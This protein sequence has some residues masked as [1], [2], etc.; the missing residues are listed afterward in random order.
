MHKAGGWTQ[1]NHPTTCPPTLPLCLIICRGC[2][3]DYTTKETKPA[4]V[5]ALEVHNGPAGG[6]FTSTAIDFWDSLLASGERVTAVA[7]S[8]SHR[9][10]GG[11]A[12]IGIGTT[13]VYAEEL[14]EAGIRDAVLAGHAYL[15]TNG[16]GSPDLRFEGRVVG[17]SAPPVIMGDQIK[18][19]SIELDASVSGIDDETGPYELILVKDNVPLET[20]VIPAAPGGTHTF[21]ATGPG[22]YRLEFHADGILLSLTNPIYVKGK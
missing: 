20:A 9:A 7:S 1:L 14:S 3:W 4:Q 10:G 19:K 2:A 21:S 5:D 13:V 11:D 16:P 18:G 15:K 22:R 8:D 17:S 6:L 12:P